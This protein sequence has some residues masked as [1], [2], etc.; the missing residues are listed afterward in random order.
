MPDLRQEYR[1]G[2]GPAVPNG[3]VGEVGLT[4][5]RAH[6]MLKFWRW[7]D[8]SSFEEPIIV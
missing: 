2:T 4:H 5:P 1:I 7:I 6:A 3:W 8:A